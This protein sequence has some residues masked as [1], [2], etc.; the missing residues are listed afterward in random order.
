[1]LCGVARADYLNGAN[2]ALTLNTTAYQIAAI[3]NGFSPVLTVVGANPA[4]V[5]SEAA[6]AALSVKAVDAEDGD[7]TSQIKTTLAVAPTGATGYTHLHTYSVT[8]GDQNTQ[9]TSRKINLVLTTTDSDDDGVTDDQDAFPND[10]AE[11]LGL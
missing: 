8:D 7:L 6:I 11:N 4:V 5:T 9:S 2:A 1:M 10:P 3:S